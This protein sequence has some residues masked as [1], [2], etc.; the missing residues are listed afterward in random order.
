MK[1]THLRCCLLGE[2]LRRSLS[3]ASLLDLRAPGIWMLLINL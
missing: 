1:N 3:Y 2:S